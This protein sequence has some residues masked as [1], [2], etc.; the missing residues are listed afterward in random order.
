VVHRTVNE[1]NAVGLAGP[2]DA[3][4]AGPDVLA[5]PLR[6]RG[7]ADPCSSAGVYDARGM[8]LTLARGPEA[9]KR[10]APDRE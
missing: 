9:V 4:E 6:A 7:G 2:V 8:A 3:D 5:H 1:S 10:P